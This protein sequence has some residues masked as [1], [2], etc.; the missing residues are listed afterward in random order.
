MAVNGKYDSS[1]FNAGQNCWIL[2]HAALCF[3]DYF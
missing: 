2:R 3:K 1:S